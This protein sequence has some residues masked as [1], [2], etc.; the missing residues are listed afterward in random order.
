MYIFFFFTALVSPA[1][2]LHG[3]RRLYFEELPISCVFFFLLFLFPLSLFCLFFLTPFF[4][5]QTLAW[6]IFFFFFFEIL[7]C[8]CFK[9]LC[10]FDKKKKSFRRLAVQLTSVVLPSSD[11]WSNDVVED[12]HI[13]HVISYPVL[14]WMHLDVV[15]SP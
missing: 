14:L 6:K 11:T 2:D 9:A 4:F 8:G 5:S 7:F 13:F 10:F 1:L 3:I 15:S 12:L